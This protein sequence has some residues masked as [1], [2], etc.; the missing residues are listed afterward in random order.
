MSSFYWIGN[1][2]ALDLANT[3]A[4][5]ENGDPVELLAT[6]D[7]LRAWVVEGG[8]ALESAVRKAVNTEHQKKVVELVLDLRAEMK[9]MA[10]AL[11]AG[12][13][14][15]RSVIEKINEVLG[16]KEGHFE[17]VQTARGYEQ[18]FEAGTNDIADLLLPIA[19]AAMDLLCFGD[20]KRVKKC[21]NTA[22]VLY[23]YDTSKPGHRRWCSMAACGNR[24]KS[25][26]FYKRG[27]T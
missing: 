4:A 1:N 15:P 5:D 20:L 14:P 13:R 19:E 10:S 25:A 16:Q 17:V 22:C 26:A 23:F 12:K 7:D 8:I 2:L 9:L 18:K 21:E 24:A 3:L 6:F 11:A 27:K